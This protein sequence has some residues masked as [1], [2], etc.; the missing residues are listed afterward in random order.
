MP[1]TN[2]DIEDPKVFCHLAGH[3]PLEGEN[4]RQYLERVTP[5]LGRE[6]QQKEEARD[7]KIGLLLKLMAFAVIAAIAAAAVT[8]P[9]MF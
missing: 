4:M 6:H 1:T 8:F 9:Y 3:P 2:E 5:L 7:R